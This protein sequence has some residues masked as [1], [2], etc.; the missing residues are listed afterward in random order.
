MFQSIKSIAS[1]VRMAGASYG[2]R[3]LLRFEGRA[4]SF[5]EADNSTAR[6]SDWLFDAGIKQGDRIGIML[7][8]GLEFP[9]IWLG[10][11]RFGAIAG[12]H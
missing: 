5:R 11:L 3:Q 2:E 9:L 4:I 7:P 8:N 10:I 6:V 12:S 1:L